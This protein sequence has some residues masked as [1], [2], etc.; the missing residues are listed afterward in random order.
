MSAFGAA[1]C[2]AMVTCAQDLVDTAAVLKRVRDGGRFEETKYRRGDDGALEMRFFADTGGVYG[3]GERYRALL[4][5]HLAHGLQNCGALGLLAIV[6]HGSGDLIGM[7]DAAFHLGALG[8]PT[9]DV[10]LRQWIAL[11][12]PKNPTAAE[13]LDRRLAIREVLRRS[14]KAASGEFASLARSADGAIRRDA[15]AALAEANGMLPRARLDPAAV[16]FPREGVAY[17]VVDHARLPD[18][19]WITSLARHVSKLRTASVIEAAGGSISEATCNGAQYLADLAGELPFEL[20]RLHGNAR[21]DHSFVAVSLVPQGKLPFGL[22]WQAAGAFEPGWAAVEPL[23]GSARNNP[24]LDGTLAVAADRL[25]ANVHSEVG[26]SDRERADELLRDDAVAIR[27][28]VP[29]GSA[30][31]AMLPTLDLPQASEAEARVTFGKGA[32][33]TATIHAADAESAQ[34]WCDLVLGMLERARGGIADAPLQLGDD[35]AVAAALRQL[36]NAKVKADEAGVVSVEIELDAITMGCVRTVAEA[37][38][39]RA[40]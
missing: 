20:A 13:L 39:G 10:E 5:E 15:E 33:L 22:L 1:C 27:A 28:V 2:L 19:G 16:T 14:G 4:G 7:T 18:L 40:L 34:A 6:C 29:K 23:P 26:E 30:L 8:L 35:P 17:V 36:A 24:L 3:D 11:P 38:A 12:L 31:C 32:K 37:M 21:I 25:V 9:G